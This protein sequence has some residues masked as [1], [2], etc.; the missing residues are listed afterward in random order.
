MFLFSHKI[1]GSGLKAGKYFPASGKTAANPQERSGEHSKSAPEFFLPENHARPGIW[2][3]YLAV[4]FDELQS[5]GSALLKSVRKPVVYLSGRKN[6]DP[7]QSCTLHAGGK[8]NDKMQ[9][10]RKCGGDRL[11]YLK[12]STANGVSSHP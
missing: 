3:S 8:R 1:Q 7:K 9:T 6:R 5:T 4:W 2:F 12:G 10:D 11:R